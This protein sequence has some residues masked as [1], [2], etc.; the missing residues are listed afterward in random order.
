MIKAILFDCFG[1]LIGTGYW[2][3]YEKMGGDLTKDK[4]FLDNLLNKANLGVLSSDALHT[5]TSNRLGIS[6]EE[7]IIALRND[8]KPNE[9]VF[10]L[11][12]QNLKNRYKLGLLSNVGLGSMERKMPPDLL[13]LF[14]AVIISAEV[15][16]LKPDPEIFRYAALK[17][18]VPPEKILFIDDNEEYLKGAEKIGMKGIKFENIKQLSTELLGILSA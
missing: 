10:A 16:L 14:D 13:S 1:V 17:L 2:K 8:E 6:K 3:V 18:Q 11:I 9:E 12:K 15:K 7:W 4:K 5:A